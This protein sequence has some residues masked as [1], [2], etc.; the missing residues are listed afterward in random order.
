MSPHI[1]L[2]RRS[3]HNLSRQLYE[4]LRRAIVA[5]AIAPGAILPSTRAL[6]SDLNLSR[7]TVVTAYTRLKSEG[8]VTGQDGSGTYVSSAL[9]QH[10]L[11]ELSA[12]NSEVQSRMQLAK[13]SSY[14]KRMVTFDAINYTPTEPEIAFYGWRGALDFVPVRRLSQAFT[15]VTRKVDPEL[16]DYCSDP[17]GYR[18]LRE[19]IARWLR[20]TRGLKTS[21]NQIL[22]VSGWR[23]AVSL[24]ARIH[25]ERGDVVAVE[26]PSF[27]S[28]RHSFEC[29][30]ASIFP[31]SVDDSGMNVEP[32]DHCHA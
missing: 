16:L 6:A 32:V 10:P 21:E 12:P 2:D 29:E 20:K 19:A 26:N 5:G 9:P 27:P 8:Y 7:A 28:I 30:G 14:A 15:H 24:I 31:V 18:P 4:E 17:L 13:L 3:R 1:E 11:G 22:I 23:Q 25:T